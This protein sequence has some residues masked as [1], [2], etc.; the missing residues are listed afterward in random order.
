MKEPIYPTSR[1]VVLLSKGWY[2]HLPTHNIVEEIKIFEAAWASVDL[3]YFSDHR[4]LSLVLTTFEDVGST[5]YLISSIKLLL[6]NSIL[7]EDPNKVSIGEFIE[8]IM[9]SLSIMNIDEFAFPLGNPD[10]RITKEML[11]IIAKES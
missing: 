4:A 11:E 5:R 2:P 9:S 6:F 8:T 1:H 10:P 7:S 3:S